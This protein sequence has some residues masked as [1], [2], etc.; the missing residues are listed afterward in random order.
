[1]GFVSHRLNLSSELQVSTSLRLPYP[2]Q[3]WLQAGWGRYEITPSSLVVLPLLHWL[4][5]VSALSHQME[6]GRENDFGQMFTIASVV[7]WTLLEGLWK[8]AVPS[9]SCLLPLHIRFCLWCILYR[10]L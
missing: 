4:M 7:S 9:F 10:S 8:Q 6:V 1:M 2:G 5:K 3:G